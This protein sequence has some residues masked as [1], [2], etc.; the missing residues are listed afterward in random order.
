MAEPT[1]DDPAQIEQRLWEEIDKARFGMLGLVG[2]SPRHFQPMTAFCDREARRIWFY[3]KKS[4]DLAQET[5]AGHPAMFCLARDQAFQAC[6][7]GELVEDHDRARIDYYW[8]AHVSAWFPGGKDDP[9]LTLLRLAAADARV[10]ASQKGPLNYA[11]QVAKANLT[12]TQPNVGT[13]T[14]LKL[15]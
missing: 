8:S 10:W 15:G 14:D 6:I 9:D 11:W 7:G 13:A 5:G 1:R 4:S 12:K 2:G 3:T